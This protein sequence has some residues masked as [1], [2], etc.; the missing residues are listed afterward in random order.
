MFDVYT[1]KPVALKKVKRV[2]VVYCY[3]HNKLAGLF[4]I[5]QICWADGVQVHVV[6]AVH[7]VL[8]ILGLV[9][10]DSQQGRKRI[11]DV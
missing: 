3:I 1:R 7:H 8:F 4:L 9:L 5:K 10:G 6:S 2:S 11:R